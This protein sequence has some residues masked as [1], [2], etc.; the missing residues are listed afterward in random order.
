[1]VPDALTVNVVDCPWVIVTD[2]GCDVIDGGVH[3]ATVI[4]A[5]ALLTVPH[6]F[7]TRTQYCD[8]TVGETVNDG[9]VAPACG[10]P[11]KPDEPPNHWYVRPLPVVPTVSVTGVPAAT[12]VDCGC[13]VIVGGVHVALT[14][15]VALTLSAAPQALVTRTQYCDVLVGL[16]V[17]LGP[18]APAWG[19]PVNP[20]APPYH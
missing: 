3:D 7:E 12:V 13:D 4:V 5:V 10:A 9:P 18:V 16:T 17:K 1:P 14:V 19:A 15:I 2:C 11:V 8:V 20:D 6:E